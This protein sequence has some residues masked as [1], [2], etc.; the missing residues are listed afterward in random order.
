M[1]DVAQLAQRVEELAATVEQIASERD[2]YKDERDAYHKLYLEML[3]RNRELERGLLA[4]KTERLAPTDKQLSMA[5]VSMLMS[6]TT[7]DDEPAEEQL[8]KPHTRRKPKRKP[9]P[10]HLPRREHVLLPT[11]VEEEGIDAFEQIGE[12]TVEV[13]ERRP[14]SAVVLRFIKPKFMRKDRAES[15]NTTVYVA[16]TPTQPIPRSV[17]GPG[18]QADSIVKRFDDHLPLNRQERIY[19]REGLDLARSTI[20][21]WHIALAELC[22]PV[23]D[24]MR[25]D[26]FEQPYLCT[27]AT[28]VLVQAKE[29]CRTGH[30]WVMVAP[31]RH[32]LFE[33]TKKHNS[34]AVDA[35]LAG[36]E[37]YLVADAHAVYDHLYRDGPVKEVNCWAH[38]RRYYF[39][40]MTSDPERARAAL[41]LINAL[42]R[43]ERRIAE[44]PRKHREK[45]RKKHS[46]PIVDRFFSWCEAE[47]EHVLDDTPVSKG[48]RYALNQREGLSRFLS[49]GRLPLHN[50]MSELELR[51]E[52]VGRKNWLFIGSEDGALANTTFVSLIASC[53]MHDVEP[54]SYLRDIFC[55]LPDWP[56]HRMLELAPLN[57]STTAQLE[58]VRDR[59]GA[60]LYRAATLIEAAPTS[61]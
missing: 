2:D 52:A 47:R 30:F 19:R 50:N 48:I 9:L 8:I 13:L 35:V 61:A 26:A 10:E 44:K 53:R 23:V 28:G 17:A 11:E 16:Q 38:A 33:F 49:D 43:I 36:Y 55:L 21:G 25:H 56:A 41:G 7:D 14:S 32:V 12:E 51:R 54:W 59:L 27:D 37:G 1:T 5:M 3:E 58:H 60:N 42:F 29:R 31:E 40:S 22:R 4:S 39:K 45:I 20:C 34:D 6:A 15:G 24:A 57:W 18:M 46:A